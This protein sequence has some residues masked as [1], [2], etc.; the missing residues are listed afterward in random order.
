MPDHRRV[1]IILVVDDQEGVRALL[2]RELTERGHTV[3]EA[4]DGAE[5]L[6]LVRRRNGAVD[7]ILCDVVMPQMNGTELAT[8]IGVEF[9]DVPVILMS[10]F[11]PAGVARVGVSETL[12]P[13]LQKPFEPTQLAELVQLAL[14]HPVPHRGAPGAL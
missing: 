1:G 5:A 7:L 4:G 9:P 13:V 2:R 11:T 3:V 10:A 8:R 14:E 12:V 6:H